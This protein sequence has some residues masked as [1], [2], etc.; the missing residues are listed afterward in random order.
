MSRS[1]PDVPFSW[2]LGFF[3]VLL[4][5]FMVVWVFKSAMEAKAYNRLTGADAT[6]WEAMWVSLRV[7]GEARGE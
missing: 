6:T 1:D 2:V 4:A 5:F 7:Q 3:A